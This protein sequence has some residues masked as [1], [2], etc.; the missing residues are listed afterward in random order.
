LTDTPSYDASISATTLDLSFNGK[1]LSTL[2]WPAMEVY[3]NSDSTP[4]NADL[5]L[6]VSDDRSFSSLISA[7]LAA[8]FKPD[9]S[10]TLHVDGT[11]TVTVHVIGSCLSGFSPL[12]CSIAP[13]S[14]SFGSVGVSIPY[15]DV[16]FSKDV[17]I[18][19]RVVTLNLI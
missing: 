3:K 11:T 6:A 12:F 2:P 14:S 5:N 1:S 4:F 8:K 17:T 16:D 7:L 9:G 13:L 10:V 15:S 18:M 19:G